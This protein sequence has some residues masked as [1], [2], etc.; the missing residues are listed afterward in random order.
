[1]I[2]IICRIRCILVFYLADLF[3]CFLFMY[4]FC[5]FCLAWFIIMPAETTFFFVWMINLTQSDM[6][7][8]VPLRMNVFPDIWQHEFPKVYHLCAHQYR[9]EI[10]ILAAK[11][12]RH[13]VRGY[14][15]FPCST[16]LRSK[17]ILLI[18]VKMPTIFGILTLISRINDKLFWFNSEISIEFG[19][20]SIHEQF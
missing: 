2:F 4:S 1:M 8:S 7:H 17:F 3:I 14:K 16:Q 10:S 5:C 12:E 13:R 19:Y 9:L 20:F 15:T 18:N 11:I 6:H